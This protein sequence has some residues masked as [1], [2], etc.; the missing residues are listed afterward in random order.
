MED[1]TEAAMKA[2]LGGG[3]I[4]IKFGKGSDKRKKPDDD[5]KEEDAVNEIGDA[6]EEKNDTS[7]AATGFF[8]DVSTIA[9]G[10]MQALLS[11]PGAVASDMGRAVKHFR[12]GV[13]EEPSPLEL[14]KEV[15]EL[16]GMHKRI[17]RD[18]HAN[19][20]TEPYKSMI[21]MINDRINSV[22]AQM[23]AHNNRINADLDKH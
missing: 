14:L 22:H 9:K 17:S 15:E 1:M 18:S 2:L 3:P 6:K 21:K 7:P 20:N 19:V 13:R 10:A 5:A 8:P 12:Q 23:T 4:K 11:M 16:I